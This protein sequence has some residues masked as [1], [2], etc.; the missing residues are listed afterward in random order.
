M[1]SAGKIM[2]RLFLIG[3]IIGMALE[4]EIERGRKMRKWRRARPI[5]N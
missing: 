1:Y 2:F 3:V 5:D 4:K